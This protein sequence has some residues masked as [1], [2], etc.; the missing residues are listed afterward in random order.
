L[1]VAQLR[2]VTP[3]LQVVQCVTAQPLLD[4]AGL[5]ADEGRG[6]AD[7]RIPRFGSAAHPGNHL[8]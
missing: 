1:L 3:G 2:Q 8:R 5:R 7:T 4:L 6:G